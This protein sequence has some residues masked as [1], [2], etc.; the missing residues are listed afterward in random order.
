M[1]TTNQSVNWLKTYAEDLSTA[2]T[3][4]GSTVVNATSGLVQKFSES[5]ILQPIETY[6]ANGVKQYHKYCDL[7]QDISKGYSK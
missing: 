2:S 3:V 6:M 1:F 4:W 7:V 5:F